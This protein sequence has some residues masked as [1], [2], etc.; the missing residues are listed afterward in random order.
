MRIQLIFFL[1]LFS[2]GIQASDDKEMKELFKNYEQVMRHH[3]VELVDD[4]FT[5]KFIKDNGGKE[6]FV[7]KVKELPKL[8]EKKNLR[9]LLKSWWK[10]KT[11]NMLFAKIKH[12]D[13][14][15]EEKS[16]GSSFVIMREEGKLKIDGTVSDG[17]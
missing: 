12:E 1:S 14:K 15:D 4:V 9:S 8:K 2:I 7:E 10:S 3:K 17:E 5:K 6:E 11:G 16:H 13:K